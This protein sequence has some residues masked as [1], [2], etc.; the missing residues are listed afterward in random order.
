M[1][2]M[3]VILKKGKV[4]GADLNPRGGLAP[5]DHETERRR[6]CEPYAMIR[7]L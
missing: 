6:R 5:I 2:Q 7:E 3:K 1:F 4:R